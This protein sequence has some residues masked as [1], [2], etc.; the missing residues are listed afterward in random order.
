M[1]MN[2]LKTLTSLALMESRLLSQD[3]LSTFLPF[4]ATLVLKKK[5][6]T[7]DI[8]V[9]VQDF[10]D[11]YGIS[12]SRAPMQSILSKAVNTGLIFHSQDGRYLPD[13]LEM[14]KISFLCVQS[15]SI[16]EIEIVINAFTNFVAEKHNISIGES[17]AVNI[18]ISFLDE[19]SPRT[20]SGE[21]DNAESEQFASNKNLYLMG[22]FIQSTILKDSLFDTIRRISMAYLITIALTYDEPVETRTKELSDLTIYL[23]TPIVLRLL[24]LQTEE[25][26]LAYKEMFQN[27]KSAINPTFMIFQHTFDEIS[28]IIADCAN[29]IDNASYNP[30]YANQALLNF[31]KRKFSKTQVELYRSTLESKLNEMDIQIDYNEY[32]NLVHKSAQIDV[33][34]LERKLISV[35]TKNNPD[36]DIIKN[37]TTINY[38]LRSIENIVKL[39]GTK[40]SNSYN[41]LGYL[42]L[43]SNS[44]LAYI[45][46]KFTSEYWWDEKNHKSPCITDYYLGTMVWLSTPADKVESV[47][48]LKLIADCSAATTLSREVMERFSYELEKLQQE[49]GIKNS[50]YLLLRKFAYEKNYLQNLTLNEETSFKD[51]ILEQLLE[52]IKA[53][54][55]KP[56]IEAIQK[57]EAHINILESEKGDQYKIIQEWEQEKQREKMENKKIKECADETVKRIIN[58]YTPIAIAI[59][60]FCA[61]L[62][63][64]IPTFSNITVIVKIISAL[65]ALGSAIFL[66]IMKSN[67]FGAYSNLTIKISKYYQ[68]KR[69]KEKIN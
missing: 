64:V 15:K 52:D 28:G 33:E 45:C 29:W 14:Q 4:I 41:H 66:G 62:L 44:T 39:W 24:G 2:N 32:Y 12:I 40:S 25:L 34:A 30:T 6:E 50:D 43:T 36:Y 47:S 69:Y 7:I 20:I 46:R 56:L 48:K 63:Q 10:K 19:Y 42:F 3:Y 55:K 22:E 37:K 68:V 1:Q 59:F 60:S 53:D 5:Y 18:F 58:T 54:I 16:S 8:G 65:V 13:I 38:D 57:R 51:D 49:R 27:F 31:V 35:Y 21:Y 67:L 23:D 26:Q 17:E 9:I 61:I 11:E